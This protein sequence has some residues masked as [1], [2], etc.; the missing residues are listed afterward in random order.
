MFLGDISLRSTWPTLSSSL[1]ARSKPDIWKY[2]L[3]DVVQDRYSASANKETQIPDVGYRAANQIVG[4]KEHV[5][6]W[7]G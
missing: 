3:R 6:D 7:S 2:G 4:F 1:S 5:P